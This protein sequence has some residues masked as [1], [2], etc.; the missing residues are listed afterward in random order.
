MLQKE[1]KNE[2]SSCQNLTDTT[3]NKEANVILIMGQTDIMYFLLCRNE[4]HLMHNIVNQLCF[5]KC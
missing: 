3:L 1:K 4:K 2:T 5:K